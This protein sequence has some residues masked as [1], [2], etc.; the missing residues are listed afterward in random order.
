MLTTMAS[1]PTPPTLQAWHGTR[2]AWTSR[3]YDDQGVRRKKRFGPADQMSER[4]ARAAYKAWLREWTLHDR[5][6]NPNAT[7]QTYTV[8]ELAESFHQHAQATYTKNGRP[9]STVWN[10]MY[11]MQA[12]ID[13]YGARPAATIE[14]PD[15]AALRDAMIQGD[16]GV[17]AV[18]TVNDRLHWIKRAFAFAREAGRIPKDNLYD[19]MQVARLV[20][21]RCRASAPRRIEPVAE[22]WVELT[23]RHT[24]R[25]VAAM[26]DL[27]WLTGMRPAEVCSMRPADLDAAE[28]VWLYTPREHKTEH[29]GQSRV[30]AL[31]PQCQQIIQP[32]LARP[33]GANLFSPAEAR[34]EQLAARRAARKT[35]LY[36]SHAAKSVSEPLAGIGTAYTT[37]SYRKAIH[38]AARAAA[39][40]SGQAVPLWNPNQ[41]RHAAATRLNRQ[42]GLE[43][44]AVVLGHAD[45]GTTKIYARPDVA[46]AVNIA[47]QC[48]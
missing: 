18:A 39:K 3:W 24:T 42:Y 16:A 48:G 40:A 12:L 1:T 37:E 33:M 5:V 19:V 26:I 8:T 4:E 23:K 47:R 22:A 21:G 14:G 20:P 34:A 43:E 45:T 15:I 31:G 35:P 10:V 30:I 6:R 29:L 38:H 32:F 25:V 41:L 7:P 27:Q 2:R 44:V 28:D 17:R 36:P 13:T 9:T 11:A 46:K